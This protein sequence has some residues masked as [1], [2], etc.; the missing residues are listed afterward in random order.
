[1][2]RT[3]RG[4]YRSAFDAAAGPPGCAPVVADEPLPA[5]PAPRPVDPLGPA[6]APKPP[7]PAG[8]LFVGIL[9]R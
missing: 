9:S 1:M 2:V 7:E 4:R 3:H 8:T 5:A 6:I